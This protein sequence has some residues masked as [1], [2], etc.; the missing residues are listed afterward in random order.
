MGTLLR[1]SC[2]S[3]HRLQLTE[4]S[5]KKITLLTE[6]D[7]LEVV[8]MAVL[9]LILEEVK[10]LQVCIHCKSSMDR[11][12]VLKNRILMITRRLDK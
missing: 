7:D 8:Q 1:Y 2:L 12:Q 4:E 10:V 9:K 11:I 5:R 3:C 6:Q